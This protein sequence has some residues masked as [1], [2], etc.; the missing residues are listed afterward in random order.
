M[1][2]RNKKHRDECCY[3]H[4]SPRWVEEASASA[5][6]EMEQARGAMVAR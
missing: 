1:A 5:M 6:Y 2:A 3:G 4:R